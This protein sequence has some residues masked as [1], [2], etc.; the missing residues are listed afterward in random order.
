M[1]TKHTHT[2]RGH[3][4]LCAS[5]QA[6]DMRTGVIAKHGY[7]VEHGYFQGECPG[8]GLLSLHTERSKC[9]A[10]IKRSR[11][12]AASCRETAAKYKAGTLFPAYAWNGEYHDE[13]DPRRPG[14]TRK[15]ETM[16]DFGV[17]PKY[18]QE[19]R[20]RECIYAVEARAQQCERYADTMTKWAAE[21]FDGKVPAYRVEQLEPKGWKIGD[22]IRI[23][24][25]KGYD[26][27]IEAIEDRPYRTNG[28]SRGSS[29]VMTP[30]ALVTHPARPE[31]RTKPTKYDP[32]GYVL[33]KAR[34]AV[35]SWE[36]LRN[37]KRE[38]PALAQRL[39]REGLL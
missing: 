36:P 24:G 17:A 21:I 34:A 16:V 31:K 32:E 2:H 12:T 20:V 9:D 7:T 33:E 18:Y 4:Q 39:K 25:R 14:K 22:T 13:P 3:C 30:H 29:S 15:A 10:E 27:T 26:V 6:I 35:Q 38:A 19:Q 37:C 23:G 8:S 11:E 28:F 5:V 1:S